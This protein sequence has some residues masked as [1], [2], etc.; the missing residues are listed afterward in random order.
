MYVPSQEKVKK[1]EAAKDNDSIYYIK[2]GKAVKI[3][4]MGENEMITDMQLWN[5]NIGCLLTMV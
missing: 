2:K 4:E 5:N 3:I 1:K